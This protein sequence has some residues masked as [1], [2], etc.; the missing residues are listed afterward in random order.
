MLT[1]KQ[2]ADLTG[3]TVKTLYHYHKVGLLQPCEITESGYRLYG[4]NELKRLQNILFYKELDF[5][6]DIIQKI[7]SE[8][9]V[10][11]F[12]L[13]KKNCL[14]RKKRELVLY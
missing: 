11:M 13:S 4:K 5:S 2:V 9:N 7:L 8:R 10:T 6:L 12:Y 3:I 1:V 14:K